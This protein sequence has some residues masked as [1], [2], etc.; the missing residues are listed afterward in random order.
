MNR[1]RLVSGQ[2]NLGGGYQQQAALA[3]GKADTTI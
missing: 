1:A 3:L 2:R